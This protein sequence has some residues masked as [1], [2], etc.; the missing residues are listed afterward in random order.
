MCQHFNPNPVMCKHFNPN[1]NWKA[2]YIIHHIQVVIHTELLVAAMCKQ[3]S[4]LPPLLTN[5]ANNSN[6]LTY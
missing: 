5:T 4:D 3:A 2:V 1:Q 6:M